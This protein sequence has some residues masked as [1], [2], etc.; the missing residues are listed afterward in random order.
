MLY[1]ADGPR[2]VSVLRKNNPVSVDIIEKEDTSMTIPLN[3]SSNCNPPC[4]AAWYKDGQL[5]VRN[6]P[7]INITLDR[8]KS[9]VYQCEASGV[10]GKLNSTEVNITIQ[11]KLFLILYILRVFGF[12]TV[13]GKRN[14]NH[15]YPNSTP[16]HIQTA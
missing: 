10:Q 2:T 3:C 4:E 15:L 7:V 8:R 9:G 11:C 6:N 14:S 16:F 12:Q 5:E 1:L 13:K